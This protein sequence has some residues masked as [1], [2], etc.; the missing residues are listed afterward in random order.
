MIHFL[1][2]HRSHSYSLEIKTE[3]QKCVQFPIKPPNFNWLK[4]KK[5]ISLHSLPYNVQ[6]PGTASSSSSSPNTYTELPMACLYAHQHEW[7]LST[8]DYK[9]YFPHIREN[10][11]GYI[12]LKIKTDSLIN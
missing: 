10:A 4:K 12:Y 6:T 1:S 2:L 3:K 7:Q 11:A 5:R 8:R 9:M